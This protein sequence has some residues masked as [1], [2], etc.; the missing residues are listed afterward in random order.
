[1]ELTGSRACAHGSPRAGD[2]DLGAHGRILKPSA[3][4]AKEKRCIMAGATP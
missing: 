3:L 1:L 2:V 4:V